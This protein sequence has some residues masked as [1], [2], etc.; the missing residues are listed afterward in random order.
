MKIRPVILAGGEGKRLAPLST[1]GRPKPFIPL[2]DGQ[3]LLEKTCRRIHSP[4]FLPPILIG[5]VK[6]RYA[7]MNHARA[8]GVIPFAILIEDTP[9]NTAFAV[10]AAM[11][12]VKHSGE[13]EMLAFLPADHIIDDELAWREAIVHAAAL[14]QKHNELALIGMEYEVFSSGLGYMALDG[15]KVISFI[16]KP[17]SEK[18]LAGSEQFLANSGQFIG[19]S[20]RFSQLL[21]KKCPKIWSISEESIKNSQKQWEYDVLA[22]VNTPFEPISFDNAVLVEAEKLYATSCR[23][24]WRDLGTLADWCRY[25]LIPLEDQMNGHMR[26][27]RPWG[28]YELLE[29]T[30]EQ[31]T[32]RLHVFPGC[33]L[34]RQRHF[35]RS[36]HWTIE[37]G[38]ASIEKDSEHVTLGIYESIKIPPASW[39]RLTNASQEMLI[40]KE[41]QY[42]ISDETDIERE[43]DDYGR[44]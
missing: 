36:E 5:N 17:E 30:T 28:Y 34:S 11:H 14:A 20:Q 26:I 12:F 37:S 7:L 42:G 9:C 43:D 13:D 15:E 4:E 41:I 18:K 2:P 31:A 40:I 39:H 16:E 27:D 3:S 44:I 6:D 21:A 22:P 32:K 19:T 1:P 23:C 33:R 24:R 10:A 8:A 29:Y 35:Y 25:T 38:I